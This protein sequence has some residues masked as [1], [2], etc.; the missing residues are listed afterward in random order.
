MLELSA[1]RHAAYC[2]RHGVTY[3]PVLGNVQFSRTPHWN[4]IALVQHALA[5]GFAT[6]AWLD[7]DTLIVRDEEDFRSALDPAGGPLALARHP[8]DP[9]TGSP[10]HWNTGVM[11]IRNT[12]RVREFFRAVWEAGPLGNHCWFEQA[13]IMDLLPQFSGLVQ[14][15]DD[16]WN[17]TEAVT[18]VPNPVIKAWHGAGLGASSSI[19][20]ELL[21]LGANDTRVETVAAGF[22]H[23]GNCV[24]RAARFL[25][26]I[27]TYPGGFFGRGII[28]CGGGASY[29][30][31]VWVCVR[32]LRRVGCTLPIQVWH[33]GDREMDDTMRGLLAPLGVT[34]IDAVALRQR[35]PARILHG[36]E[37][38]SYAMRHS[39][40]KEVMLL[41][42]DNVAVVA[43]EFLF[44]APEFRAT[45]AIFWP[46]YE[47]MK[48]TRSAW[49]IF[50]VPFRDEAEFESG[51][52]V[53]DKS[54]TWRALEL[55][56]WFNDYSDFFYRHIW[57]DKDTFRFAWHRT[58]TPFSMPPFPIH[59]VED[60]MCQHD[61]T[62]RRIFQHRNTDKWSL[63][64]EN[65]RVAGFLFEQECFDDLA[66]LKTLWS[67]K[68]QRK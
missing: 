62:G 51:Q 4:K 46:D 7:A 13:R 57:G 48:A 67:G 68:V 5:L 63:R 18:E 36:W 30:P 22:V 15:L 40:F 43:P 23:E 9:Q 45:G 60:T 47:R 1:G 16:R 56:R 25:E 59:T 65:K 58:G 41:D 3:W 26:N 44:D 50:D 66:L 11:I 49:R 34:C 24:A 38:K 33:L 27:A 6:V 35:H 21:K 32:Q 12:P 17:S 52:I 28:I 39:P 64:Q 10:E 53:L 42:A 61:F 54:R 2:A 19:Y 8:A 37:L 20:D 14:K 29:F 55:T 31:C